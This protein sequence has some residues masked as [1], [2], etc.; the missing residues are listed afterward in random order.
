M[1]SGQLTQKPIFRKGMMMRIAI[2]E[3]VE[4]VLKDMMRVAM[5]AGHEVL[6]VNSGRSTYFDKKTFD[7]RPDTKE[8]FLA[9][10]F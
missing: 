6:G 10:I 3:D 4:W 9:S 7:N 8:Q 2:V 5:E 1:S